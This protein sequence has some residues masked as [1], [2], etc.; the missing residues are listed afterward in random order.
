MFRKEKPKEICLTAGR[1]HRLV[2]LV[3]FI[4]VSRFKY[5]DLLL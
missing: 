5:F 2:N 3:D 1:I 4:Y